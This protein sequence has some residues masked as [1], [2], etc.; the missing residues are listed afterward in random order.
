MN[1]SLFN[2]CSDIEQYVV[3]DDPEAIARWDAWG[4]EI[5]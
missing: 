1:I 4:I 3:F 5:M 2:L